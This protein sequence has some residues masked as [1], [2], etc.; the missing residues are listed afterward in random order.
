MLYI[1]LAVGMFLVLTNAREVLDSGGPLPDKLQEEDERREHRDNQELPS[2]Q[3]SFPDPEPSWEKDL[4]KLK[5]EVAETL[6][7]LKEEKK[8][9][10]SLKIEAEKKAFEEMAKVSPEP[11]E[12]KNQIVSD[13][14]QDNNVTYLPHKIRNTS[15]PREEEKGQGNKELKKLYER[16]HHL[17]GKGKDMEEIARHLNM[18]KGEVELILGL[19]R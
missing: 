10:F 6:K 1:L 4:E 11:R 15:S 16:V 2:K 9:Y 13:F 7:D 17:K 19:K 5:Q 12:L 14:Y 3:E 8:E 18:G